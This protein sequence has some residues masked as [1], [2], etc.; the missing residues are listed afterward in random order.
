MAEVALTPKTVRS[1][2]TAL[3]REILRRLDQVLPVSDGP[4]PLHE[5]LFAG[6]EK[7][8][9]A[10]CIDTGWV[11]SVGPFV[12]RFEAELS[13][14]TGLNAVAT[15]NGTAA[16]HV[17]LR[18]A[19]VVTNDEVLVPSLTFVATANAVAYCG[20][21]PH[22]VDSEPETL[23][24]D[25]ARLVKY[26]ENTLE[27][28]GKGTW[29]N[30]LTKRPV[31][32]MLVTHI[33]GHPPKL[34]R[35]RAIAD[36]YG[37]VLIEDAAEALGSYHNGT[38]AG[39]VGDCAALSFNGNK[40]I[41]AGGGGAV[42]TGNADLAKRAKHLTTTARV[43]DGFEWRHDSVGF[44][45]R[46]P[47]INAALACAQL[48]QL[49]QFL[50]AK[51]RLAEDYLAAFEDLEEVAILSEPNHG[52]S[53][54]WLNTLVLGAAH[55]GARDHILTETNAAGYQCRP[56]WTPMN[57]LPMYTDCPSMELT[58]A[59]RLYD[60]VMNLPSGPALRLG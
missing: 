41:T 3:A 48:Q 58:A 59:P 38:H 34:D 60:T 16:L 37:M 45:Y 20:A 56:L 39:S 10:E 18:L 33:F 21:H 36:Q 28:L 57:R 24:A 12:D 14:F 49:P 51:R 32:A 40:T 55:F 47:N 44:N 4:Y 43:A 26:L 52:H 5:P 27:P 2:E 23:G 30:R 54:Y 1:D 7:K 8:Y 13:A 6:N 22:F 9:L 15:T 46:M 11:S 50:A 35:L 25:P 53:N 42:I 29:C 31:R 17:C 19:G